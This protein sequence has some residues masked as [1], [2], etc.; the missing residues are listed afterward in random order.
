MH[1]RGSTHSALRI[2]IMD[3]AYTKQSHVVNSKNS[4][5]GLGQ[6]PDLI[7]KWEGDF[8]NPRIELMDG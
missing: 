2:Q 7:G 4:F 5:C 3:Y 8:A 1:S 6:I